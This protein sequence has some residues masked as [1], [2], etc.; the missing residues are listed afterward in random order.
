MLAVRESYLLLVVVVEA[1]TPLELTVP[2]DSQAVK[3]NVAAT[4][5]A[6]MARD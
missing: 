4:P 3:P 6:K 1:D 2:F 5:S